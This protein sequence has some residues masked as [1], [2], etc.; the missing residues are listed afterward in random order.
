M[1]T[2]DQV[3]EA[4]RSL[5]PILSRLL[6]A[7]VAQQVD[8]QLAALLNH[9]DLD[10]ASQADGIQEILDSYPATKTWLD[11]FLSDNSAI[12]KNYSGLP[13][14]PTL[15]P[16]TKYVCPIGNDYTWYQ[17]DNRPIPLCPTHLVSL[18]SAQP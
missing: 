4:A 5:R 10:E 8:Q 3:L 6:D 9:P 1:F 15:T 17:E 18:V 16:A 7:E 11:D 14:D 2:N 13:G 12:P